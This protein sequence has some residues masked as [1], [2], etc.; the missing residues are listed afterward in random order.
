MFK[1]S[2]MSKSLTSK[3]VVELF[4]DSLGV[5]AEIESELEDRDAKFGP[6]AGMQNALL[7]L[8][9]RYGAE[10]VFSSLGTAALNGSDFAEHYGMDYLG[11]IEHAPAIVR[12]QLLAK[13]LQEAAS[14]MR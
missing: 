14:I 1:E 3:I 7:N 13:K 10:A 2:K 12:L 9:T 5:E 8:I 6:T 4:R 11:S